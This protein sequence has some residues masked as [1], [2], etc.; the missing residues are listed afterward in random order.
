[1]AGNTRGKIKEHF[2]GVH[3]NFD[4][5]TYHCQKLLALIGDKKPNL[6]DAVKSLDEGCK[7]LDGIVQEMY[8]KI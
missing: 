1:M 4:W 2:E 3:R 8:G 5:I 6:S 7:T